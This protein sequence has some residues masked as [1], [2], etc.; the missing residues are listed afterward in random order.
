MF[1]IHLDIESDERFFLNTKNTWGHAAPLQACGKNSCTVSIMVKGIATPF[2][3]KTHGTWE[4]STQGMER[5]VF[6]VYQ[7]TYNVCYVWILIISSQ[8][9]KQSENFLPKLTWLISG[10]ARV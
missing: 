3:S 2:R 7:S 5:D 4:M 6:G 9:K 10:S 1:I 8:M